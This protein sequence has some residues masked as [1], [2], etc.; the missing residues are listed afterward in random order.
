MN[1]RTYQRLVQPFLNSEH[2]E[3]AFDIPSTKVLPTQTKYINV[4][5]HPSN[6][7]GLLTATFS[8]KECSA[9]EAE[10]WQLLDTCKD[11]QGLVYSYLRDS[12]KITLEIDF[13]DHWPY[14]APKIKVIHCSNETHN[15]T[16]LVQQFHCDLR[17]Q[18]SPALGFEKTLLMLLVRILERIHYV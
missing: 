17:A 16:K 1:A 11:V 10:G 2:I 15:I 9:L 7:L 6:E 14:W 18:W 4:I 3:Q 5:I 12:L 13:R 8:Y